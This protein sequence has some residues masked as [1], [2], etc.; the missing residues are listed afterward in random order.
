MKIAE[1]L[2]DQVTFNNNLSV[3]VIFPDLDECTTMQH[4]CQHECINTVG[5]FQCGCMVGFRRGQGQQCIG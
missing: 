1:I 4:N 2:T 5:S 3:S